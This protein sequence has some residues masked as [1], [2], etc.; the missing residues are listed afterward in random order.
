MFKKAIIA[1]IFMLTSAFSLCAEDNNVATTQ[2]QSEVVKPEQT[3]V[4]R[5]RRCKGC[6]RKSKKEVV[7]TQK[8]QRELVKEAKKVEKKAEKV[9]EKAKKS[10]EREAKKLEK[11]AKKAA[12][13]AGKEAKRMA[14]KAKK[15][16]KKEAK[17]L[18]KKVRKS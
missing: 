2:P 8:S 17:K 15:E 14:K 9:L 1:S 11:K 16:A 10:A 6:K 7:V 13:T 3:Q 12:K 5:A 18:E 4:Q